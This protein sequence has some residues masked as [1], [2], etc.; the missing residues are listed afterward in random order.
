MFPTH[1]DIVD[2]LGVRVRR[3]RT[4]EVLA[5]LQDMVRDIMPHSV[6]IVN[7]ATVNLAWEDPTYRECLNRGHL[8]LNDGTGVRWAARWQGVSL[9]HNHVGTDLV[10][11]FC[12]KVG[13]SRLRLF[14][15]GGR[16]G[17]AERAASALVALAPGLQVAGCHHGYVSDADD[18]RICAMINRADADLVLVAMGNPLQEEWIDRN[19]AHLRK[20]VLVGVGGLFDHLAGNLR[21]A[22]LWVRQ[23]GF[24]WVQLLVQQPHKWRRYLLGNPLFLYRMVRWP[25]GPNAC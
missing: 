12:E 21:R 18:A 4:E 23:V 16:P 24:E 20:G 14:L 25:S 8:V 7:A 15:L 13:R 6:F 11:R 1:V 2:I 19:L 17:V 3:L 22:P 5:A 10:P 9:E